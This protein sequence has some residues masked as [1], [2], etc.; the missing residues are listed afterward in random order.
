VEELV[1]GENLSDRED[2]FYLD[3][4]AILEA[5]KYADLSGYEVVAMLHTH[6]EGTA[7]SLVDLEGMKLW[8]IPW[9]IIDE[10]ICSARSWIVEGNSLKNIPTDLLPA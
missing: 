6:R 1:I 4:I 5:F 3:P 8:S 7:P 10:S 2:R 9:I